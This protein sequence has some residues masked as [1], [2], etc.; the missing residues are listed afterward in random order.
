MESVS[1]IQ[2]N[3]SLLEECS[4]SKDKIGELE[5]EDRWI[6]SKTQNKIAEITDAV[7]DEVT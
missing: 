5:A 7:E 6:L 4:G 1:G 2:S 3:E